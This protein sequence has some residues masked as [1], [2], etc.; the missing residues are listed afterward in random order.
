MENATP[1]PR[2]LG[3]AEAVVITVTAALGAVVGMPLPLALQLL[4]GAGLTAVLVV[5]LLTGVT[6]RWLRTALSAFL[7]PAA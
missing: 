7:A 6:T 5:G 3:G 2:R 4:A 1:S